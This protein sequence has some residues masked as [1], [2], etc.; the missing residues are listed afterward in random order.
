MAIHLVFAWASRFKTRV[1]VATLPCQA[2]KQLRS[3]KTMQVTRRILDRKQNTQGPLSQQ[4]A[5]LDLHACRQVIKSPGPQKPQGLANG[6]GNGTRFV[7]LVTVSGDGPCLPRCAAGLGGQE[8]CRAWSGCGRACGSAGRASGQSVSRNA[9]PSR[10]ILFREDG[11]DC[12][13]RSAKGTK[14]LGRLD[15]I[16]GDDFGRWGVS[17]PRPELSCSGW[18]H[19]AKPSKTV[20]LWSAAAARVGFLLVP[21]GELEIGDPL[22]SDT[23]PPPP[24]QT[25]P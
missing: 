21:C 16:H 10:E 4:S 13:S 24:R 15:P 6:D 7:R 23:T 20:L 22:M 1:R 5:A 2:W 11:R 3:P 17:V 18:G 14:S 19:D 12:L 25:P 8:M 9:E